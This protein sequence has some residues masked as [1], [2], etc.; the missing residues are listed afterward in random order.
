MVFDRTTATITVQEGD[1]VVLR[2]AAVTEVCAAAAVPASEASRP[3]PQTPD[4]DC[5]GRSSAC[6][7]VPFQ[8]I[9]SSRDRSPRRLGT[10]AVA[11]H[12]CA[13]TV[14]ATVSVASLPL[15]LLA[16]DVTN[17][18]ACSC[19]ILQLNFRQAPRHDAAAWVLQEGVANVPAFLAEQP[20][21][22]ANPAPE[23]S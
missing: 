15:S 10:G 18:A 12:G 1:V 7:S 11:H 8:S 2:Y 14:S 17:P 9:V 5:P 21:E 3:S 22:D 16:T 19:L 23:P 13:A 20:D 4:P 6:S